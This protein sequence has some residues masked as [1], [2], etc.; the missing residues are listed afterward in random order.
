LHE[1][2]SVTEGLIVGDIDGNAESLYVGGV[3]G[4]AESL[5]LG[6]R[7]VGNGLVLSIGTCTGLVGGGV[8]RLVNIPGGSR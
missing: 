2:N 3:D 8:L 1:E 4:K 5:N 6:G 7:L